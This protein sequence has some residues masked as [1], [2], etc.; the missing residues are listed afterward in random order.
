MPTEAKKPL[1]IGALARK[2]GVSVETIRYYQ[3]QGLM[4]APEKPHGQIR[5]YDQQDVNRIRFIKSAQ[6]LGFSLKEV[7]ELLRLAD[8]THCA[9]ASQMAEHKL[10][11]VRQK[12][13]DLTHMEAAL[14]HLVSACRDPDKRVACP[15]I[16]ALESG[17]A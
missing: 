15:L 5:H 12:L 3:R 13:E 9:E 4:H 10:Q 16:V 11:D 6:G 8:G 2:A 1:S 17:G 7:S 14:D